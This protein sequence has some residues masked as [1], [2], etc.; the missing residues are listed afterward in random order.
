MLYTLAITDSQFLL[1]I[2]PATLL[3]L[4]TIIVR[5]EQVGF[6]YHL[7]MGYELSDGENSLSK[8]QNV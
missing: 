7:V 6:G 2:F 5:A 1:V 3:L 4:C 8:P